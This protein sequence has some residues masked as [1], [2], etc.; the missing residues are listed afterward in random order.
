[1]DSVRG[2][3]E[4][5]TREGTRRVKSWRQGRMASMAEG[6]EGMKVIDM[7]PPQEIRAPNQRQQRLRGRGTG[8]LTE[9]GNS[10]EV[11]VCAGDQSDIDVQ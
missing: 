5:G 8:A 10:G 1:M 11:G 2:S 6:D 3:M 9:A 7:D 4:R